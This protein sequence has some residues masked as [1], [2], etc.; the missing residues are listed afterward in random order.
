MFAQIWKLLIN[1]IGPLIAPI[2]REFVVEAFRKLLG[3]L[4]AKLAVILS[5]YTHK[6]TEFAEQKAQNAAQA[7]ARATDDA[8]RVRADAEANVWK[9]VAEELKSQNESL[10]RELKELI[11]EATK[12][13]TS[14]VE[15]DTKRVADVIRELPPPTDISR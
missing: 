4:Q 1:Y 10:L 2:F 5:T 14:Q 9:Q 3:W 12:Y 7:S 15:F 11:E 13:S 8:D 6:Q